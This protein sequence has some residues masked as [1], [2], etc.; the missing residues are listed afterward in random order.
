MVVCMVALVEG[1][2]VAIV[3]GTVVVLMEGDGNDG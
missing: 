2:M 1:A 3:A